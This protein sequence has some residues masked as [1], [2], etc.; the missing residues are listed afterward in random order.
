MYFDD[1]DVLPQQTDSC[2]V[3]RALT[4]SWHL[5]AGSDPGMAFRFLD[6]N[7]TGKRFITRYGEERICVTAAMLLT[8]PGLPALYSGD[9][10]AVD[11]E[12]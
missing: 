11:F 3:R 4:H 12:A 8:L 6:N 5:R 1:I 2:L 10:V 7:D 9:E